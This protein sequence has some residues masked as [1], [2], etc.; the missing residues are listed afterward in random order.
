M[1]N[2]VQP[3]PDALP[4]VVA[5]ETDLLAGVRTLLLENPPG[6]GASESEIVREIVLLR[7]EIGDAKKEDVAAIYQQMTHLSSL[8]DQIRKG[9]TTEEV[10]PDSPYFAHLRLEEDGRCRDVFL[11]RATRLSKGL[12]IVD[13]RNAPIS[14]LFYRYEEG[15]EY[16][17]EM[18]GRIRE[19]KIDTRRTVHVQRGALQRVDTPQTSWV[20]D[21]EQ[22]C[23]ISADS[24]RL[25]GGQGQAMRRGNSRSAKLGSGKKLRADKHLPDIA[26]LIDP[27]QFELITSPGS[28]VVVLRGSAGTGKTTV[29]LHR[30]AYLCYAHAQAFP[31]SQVLVVVWG[32]AMRDYVAHVLPALGVD[33]VQV[34]TWEGWS[35]SMVK[36]HYPRLPGVIAEDTPEPVTRIKLHPATAQLLADRAA[37]YGRAGPDEAIDDWASV[38]TDERLLAEALGDDISPRALQRA[39]S[40]CSAQTKSIAEW[41]E[42]DREV[43]ARLDPEDDA[44][45]LRAWQLRVGPLRSRK[46]RP[47]QYAHLALDEVQ[48]FSPIEVQ[49]LLGATGKKRS[50]TLAGDTRQHIT[51]H[52][53]FSSWQEFL[54]R[55]GV[56]STALN[57]LTVSYRSTHAITR[58]AISVLE[59]NEEPPARTTRDGPPV[60]LFRFS[61][62]GACVAFLATELRSLLQAEPLANIALLTP[63]EHLADLYFDGLRSAEVPDIRRVREQ[64]FA[65][66]SGIDVVPVTQ[67]KGLEFDYVVIIEASAMQWP[68]TP[69]HRRLLHVGATRAVHQ[70]WLTSVGTPT[71]ILPEVDGD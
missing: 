22:W 70:L 15:D 19:G 55:I 17:E 23:T 44:L 33:G 62:H 5:E 56:A 52:A 36:R 25:S 60:E 4:P 13:W 42:G 21:D 11:G 20:K 57:T 6:P 40:W 8:L 38:I 68:D 46:K 37:A 50:V 27:D 1:S 48:D 26:A 28:G 67:I 51:H 34:N 53:G 29:A 61:E 59:S 14:K 24:R 69:H 71:S 35:R 64:R 49:V 16:Q 47:L 58:F 30:I 63:D 43:D 45:L 54:D 9:R 10:D 39:V 65:F 18:G 3:P 2:S 41:R 66:S 31:P 7:D 12:R 32:R